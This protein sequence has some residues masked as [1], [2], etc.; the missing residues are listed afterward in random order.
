[1][2]DG[3]PSSSNQQAGNPSDGLQEFDMDNYDDEEEGM[4]YFTNLN[5]DGQ[6]AYEKDPHMTG[7]PDSDSDS[8]DY[9]QIKSDDLLFVAASCEEE[10]CQLELYVY[11]D[12]EA[13]MYVHHDIMLDAYPLCVEW[14]GD[15]AAGTGSFA[16]VGLIDNSIQIWNLDF[17]E[18]LEPSQMLGVNPKSEKKKKKKNKAARARGSEKESAHDGAVLCIHGSTFNR[19]VLAS[20]SADHCVKVW[21]ICENSCV[22]KYTH[23]ENKVQCVKWHATEQAVLLSAAFDRK[24]ALLDVRQPGQVATIGL[25]AEAESSIWS[26]H[27][28]FEC[29]ASAD[30]GRVACY[31]VRKVASKAPDEEKVLWT[32]EAHSAACTSVQDSPT[33][34]LL[35]TTSLDGHAKIWDISSSRPKMVFSKNLQAGPLFASSSCPEAPGVVSFGGNQPVVWDLTSEELLT[36]AFDFGPPAA[37]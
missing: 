22:H 6:L 4:Q 36:G 8:E 9:H 37:A 31:D 27:K 14:L 29:L 20:G 25:P 12:E 16:A 26:R 7:D 19:S 3:A 11:V 5:N 1:M 2:A 34:N 30:D 23:H 32:L 28:P 15:T 13:N 35:I 10:S 21:D 33:K 24:L 18:E 17:L